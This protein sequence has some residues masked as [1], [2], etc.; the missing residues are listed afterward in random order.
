M[1]QYFTEIW[2]NIQNFQAWPDY[3]LIAS[4]PKAGQKKSYIL[5]LLYFDQT[6]EHQKFIPLTPLQ[7]GTEMVDKLHTSPRL[8][9]THLP[10]LFVP[11]SFWE[12]NCR[13]CLI[14][15]FA[16]AM[17]TLIILMYFV[18]SVVFGSWYDHVNSWWKKKDTY[19]NLHYMFEEDLVEFEKDNMV[20]LSIYPGMDFTTLSFTKKGK[21]GDWK[22][23]FTVAQS[24]EFDEDYKKKIKDPT[25]HFHA[26]I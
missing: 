23:Y 24:E 15:K 13:V 12:Q 16:Y 17:L 3:I 21:V 6:S 1:T 19:S 14:M 2:K 11:K 25:L 18:A 4:Y 7:P 10:I 20:N 26:D 22:N 5:D 8:M 9:R